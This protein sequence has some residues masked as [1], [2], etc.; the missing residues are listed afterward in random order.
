MGTAH[1]LLM[2]RKLG[3]L[4]GAGDAPQ[5]GGTDWELL[6]KCSASDLR[7]GKASG[8]HRVL[9]LEEKKAFLL[10]RPS[11]H[12]V[13]KTPL[14]RHEGKKGDEI[15]SASREQGYS[16]AKTPKEEELQIE[17]WKKKSM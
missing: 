6:L 2:G 5:G 3:S 17:T 10:L 7:D 16:K 15:C 8:W 4:E 11:G 14:W 12:R 9:L 13:T 1:Y